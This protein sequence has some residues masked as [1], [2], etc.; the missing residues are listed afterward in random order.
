MRRTTGRTVQDQ[1]LEWVLL[2]NGPRILLENKGIETL[3]LAPG[4]VNK[5]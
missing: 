3:V 1:L 5:C 4:V 2:M